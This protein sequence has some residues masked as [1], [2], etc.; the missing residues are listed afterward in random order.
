MSK[1]T[2][3]VPRVEAYEMVAKNTMAQEETEWLIT[4]NQT[5]P[6][7][8]QRRSSMQDEAIAAWNN[9]PVKLEVSLKKLAEVIVGLDTN[10]NLDYCKSDC[11]EVD[12]DCPH[13]VECCL[14]WLKEDA[15]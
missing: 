15:R 6:T 5:D 2:T 8:P 10:A 9:R 13:P 12:S 7:K 3:V 14:R 4:A 11:A 1:R